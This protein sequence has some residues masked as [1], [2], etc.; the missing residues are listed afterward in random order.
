LHMLDL[1]CSRDGRQ[2]LFKYVL[3]LLHIIV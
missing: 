3:T 2:I 1:V